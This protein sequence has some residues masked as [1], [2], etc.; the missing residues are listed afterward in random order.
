MPSF[1][2]GIFLTI[3]LASPAF[4]ILAIKNVVILKLKLKLNE[5]LGNKQK[6]ICSGEILAV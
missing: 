6:L 4:V 1:V 5:N 3:N 2:L